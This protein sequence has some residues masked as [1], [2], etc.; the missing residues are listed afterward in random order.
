MGSYV[1]PKNGWRIHNYKKPE[2]ILMG[3]EYEVDTRASDTKEAQ[4]KRLLPDHYS[5]AYECLEYAH[6]N[7]YE[8]KSSV[9]PLFT[10]KLELLR[11]LPF[12]QYSPTPGRSNYGGIHVNISRTPYTN[13]HMKKIFEFLHNREYSNFFF[14]LSGRTRESFGGHAFQGDWWG[15]YTG[16]ITTR[17]DYAYEFRLFVAQPNR[18]YCALEMAH[19][20]FSM[21]PFVDDITQTSFTEYVRS[22]PKYKHIYALIKSLFQQEKL[23]A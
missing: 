19:A 15:S 5:Y 23:A 2:D 20:L 10:L 21:A 1:V 14:E 4:L 22:K 11:I 16:I 13:E 3:F 12:L 9:A 7:G 18:L 8:I 6:P 17:K